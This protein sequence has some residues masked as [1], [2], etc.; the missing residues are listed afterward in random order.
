MDLWTAAFTLAAC[1]L[2]SAIAFVHGGV[3]SMARLAGIQR[4]IAVAAGRRMVGGA[5]RHHLSLK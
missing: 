5:S 4:D 2:C 3:R 1:R